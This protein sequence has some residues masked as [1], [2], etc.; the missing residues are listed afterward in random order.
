MTRKARSDQLCI[1]LGLALLLPAL[2]AAMVLGELAITDNAPALHAAWTT[3]QGGSKT[4]W[5]R[6]KKR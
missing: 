5:R 6:L 1:F 2:L 3:S 4:W